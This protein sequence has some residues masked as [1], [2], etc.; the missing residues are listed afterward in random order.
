MSN[1]ANIKTGH[2]VGN[3]AAINVSIGFIP[4]YVKVIN[5]TDGDK[6]WE[7]FLGKVV[8]FSSGGTTE[9]QTGDTIKGAT[10]GATAVVLQIDLYSGTW[11]AGDA[12]GFMVVRDVVGTIAS[13]NVYVSSDS[14]SGTDDATVT[15]DVQ[16]GVDIDTEVASTTS[17]I[18]QYA[19]SSTVGS[20]AA[21]GF[22]ISSTIAEE[23]K[24][25]GYI[26]MKSWDN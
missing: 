11:A 20:E 23:A 24:S 4:D 10:S 22:T 9:I 19:G 26:A 8:P 14:T 17:A 21:P 25:L 13:E 6:V 12:A 3:G 7:G 15:V 2:L 16:K 1:T 5:L 18:I